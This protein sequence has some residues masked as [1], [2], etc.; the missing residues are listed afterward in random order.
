[1]PQPPRLSLRSNHPLGSAVRGEINRCF[2]RRSI[3]RESQV[4]T[5]PLVKPNSCFAI[6]RCKV[7]KSSAEKEMLAPPRV[8]CLSRGGLRGH[9][10]YPADQVPPR[11]SS[12]TRQKARHANHML[13]RVIK[14]SM[15]RTARGSS[16]ATTCHAA[17][18]PAAQPGVAPRSP[19]V[20][21]LQLPLPAQGSSVVAMCHAAPAPAAQPGAAPGPPRVP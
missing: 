18:A 17:P 2:A 10:R 14:F 21:R 16:G 5:R 6:P 12:R 15:N 7:P 4:A 3:P 13:P 19:R 1:L 8:H 11:T 9:C 20:L